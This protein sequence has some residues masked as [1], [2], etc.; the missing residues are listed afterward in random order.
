M[1]KS[2]TKIHLSFIFCILTLIG[3]ASAP[4]VRTIPPPTIAGFYH[5][6]EKGQTLWRISKIYNVELDEIV[7]INYIQDAA[8]IE[9]G[10]LIFIPKRQVQKTQ[11]TRQSLDD[12]IWPVKG[13]ILS[14]FGQTYN[15]MI[16]K[17]VNIQPYNDLN[18][19]TAR[20]G[21]V[22][23][24]SENFGNF[25]KTI[26]IDHGDGLYTVYARNS[27]VF[28][29]V[30]DNLDKGTII[31]KVGSTPL[32]KNIYLHFEIRKRYIPQNPLFYLP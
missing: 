15:N 31:A 8:V 7:K 21:K 26:I 24:Y 22:I 25:G 3:C 17:G 23:F 20:S 18:V 29:K 1:R 6:V 30:G 5:R 28:I 9:K 16:N 32:D 10:Q 19:I 2:K 4:Y 14:T 11:P 13:R 12:F 27:E